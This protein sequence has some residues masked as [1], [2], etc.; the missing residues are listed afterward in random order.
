[1]TNPTPAPNWGN[2]EPALYRCTG[3]LKA[4]GVPYVHFWRPSYA[5]IQDSP[6]VAAEACFE[7]QGFQLLRCDA[8]SEFEFGLY[9]PCLDRVLFTV[10]RPNLPILRAWDWAWTSVPAKVK[11]RY[12][13][14]RD[15][16][17]EQPEGALEESLRAC[18]VCLEEIV[19]AIA[20]ATAVSLP[21][22]NL[23]NKIDHLHARGLLEA[24]MRQIAHE[25]RELANPAAH[26]GEPLIDQDVTRSGNFHFRA[27]GIIALIHLEALIAHG[28]LHPFLR[29][30]H[31]R[32]PEWNSFFAWVDVAPAGPA[33]P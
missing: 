12:E 27:D 14:A 29:I 15:L 21:G 22:K 11:D 33:R 26:G 4:V 20:A 5:R 13:R 8:C 6:E 32:D 25:I 16:W 18:R 10:D 23:A 17:G 3:V 2:H 24:R 7:P 9:A 30:E 28:F 1:M 31:A 19:R